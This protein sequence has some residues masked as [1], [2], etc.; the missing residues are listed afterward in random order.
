MKEK[1]NV[2]FK[3]ILAAFILFLIVNY[4]LITSKIYGNLSVQQKNAIYFKIK[5]LKTAFI[6]NVQMKIYV[7]VGETV[8]KVLCQH[9]QY[10]F[11]LIAI[12]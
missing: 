12:F 7:V 9:M 1:F 8:L 4:T 6:S 5:N 2:L 10:H 3:L 11:L